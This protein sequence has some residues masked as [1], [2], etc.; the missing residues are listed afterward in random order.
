MQAP[1]NKTGCRSTSCSRPFQTPMQTSLIPET[2][3]QSAFDHRRE[4]A[5]RQQNFLKLTL[6]IALILHLG[7]I[8]GFANLSHHIATDPSQ[9]EVE[10]VTDDKIEPKPDLTQAIDPNGQGSDLAGGGGSSRFSLLQT[11]GGT[12]E[13]NNI[14]TLGNPFTATSTEAVPQVQPEMAMIPVESAP[15]DAI[16]PEKKTRIEK[17]SEKKNEPPSNIAKTDEKSTQKPPSTPIKTNLGQLNGKKEGKGTKGD[18]NGGQ[19]NPNAAQGQGTSSRSGRGYGNGTN[20]NGTRPGTIGTPPIIRNPVESNIQNPPASTV[21]PIVRPNQPKK[22]PRKCIENCGLNDYLG[23]EGSLRIRQEIGKDGKVNPV[24]VQSSGD[25]ELD[26]KA[27]E[28]MKNRRYETS[29][30]DTTSNIRVT[31]QQEGSDFT[32]QQDDRRQRRQTE[33]DAI[34]RERAIQ[35][36]ESR[37]PEAVTPVPSKPATETAAEPAP[38]PAAPVIPEPI[39][40][41][42]KPIAVPTESAPE[43]APTTPAL[44]P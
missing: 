19:L 8:V 9:D 40:P 25:S 32:R 23:S 26:R 34:V 38:P 36:Q 18:P 27:L 13:G 35:E 37:K 43:P 11:V 17:K 30:S 20:P 15:E 2:P 44:V 31:S 3:V 4:E 10:I 42:P 24:L 22:E 5:K 1:R 39:P 7:A 28:A 33:Q 21:A 41:V 29:D 6:P 16:E 14:A 12:T